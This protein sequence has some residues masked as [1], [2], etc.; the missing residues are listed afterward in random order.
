MGLHKGIAD[1]THNTKPFKAENVLLKKN[2]GFTIL[3]I[4]VSIL[5]LCIG[6]VAVLGLQ[7]A[8]VKSSIDAKNQSAALELAADLASMMRSNPKVST[9]STGNPYL[10]DRNKVAPSASATAADTG[11]LTPD[12]RAS[13]DAEQWYARLY[14]A[15]PNAR[16]LVCFDSQPYDTAGVPQWT[17]DGGKNLYIKIGWSLR[18]GATGADK[19]DLGVPGVVVPV[20]VCNDEQTAASKISCYGN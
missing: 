2:K 20:G 3:E 11:S 14:S 6:V 9:L 1:R 10:L 15:L 16:V 5:I 8:S 12:E 4:L 7:V 17:C 19:S 18:S 13:N